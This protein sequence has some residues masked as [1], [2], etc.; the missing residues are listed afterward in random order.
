MSSTSGDDDP[1]SH[2]MVNAMSM[3]GAV[4]DDVSRHSQQ[5]SSSSPRVVHHDGNEKS[6]DLNDERL[7]NTNAQLSSTS[8]GQNITS[9]DDDTLNAS[10]TIS[11]NEQQ[12]EQQQLQ[13]NRTPL[14]NTHSIMNDLQ[15]T[16]QSTTATTATTTETTT[17]TPQQQQRNGIIIL[18]PFHLVHDV[19]EFPINNRYHK[20][21]RPFLERYEEQPHRVRSIDHENVNMILGDWTVLTMDD[22][23]QS[24]YHQVAPPHLYF[25]HHV[26][27]ESSVMQSPKS[28]SNSHVS[29]TTN[30][31]NLPVTFSPQ[32]QQQQQ[33]H[34]QHLM[35]IGN[36]HLRPKQLEEPLPLSTHT[37]M[38]GGAL[39]ITSSLNDHNDSSLH[40]TQQERTTNQWSTPLPAHTGGSNTTTT[41]TTTTTIRTIDNFNTSSIP[42]SSSHYNGTS[43]EIAQRH[44]DRSTHGTTS[45][46]NVLSSNELTYSEEDLDE[47]EEESDLSSINE[48]THTDSLAS[49]TTAA[50]T[51]STGA[52]TTTTSTTTTT[53]TKKHQPGGNLLMNAVINN[54]KQQTKKNTIASLSSSNGSLNGNSSAG[55]IGG[56]NIGNIGTTTTTTDSHYLHQ[57]PA[58]NLSGIAT[59]ATTTTTDHFNTSIQRMPSSSSSTSGTSNTSHLVTTPKRSSP[60]NNQTS[61]TPLNNFIPSTSV[62]N[63][64]NK[65]S[66]GHEMISQNGEYNSSIGIPRVSGVHINSNIMMTSGGIIGSNIHGMTST[67]ATI[68]ATN[69]Y[70]YNDSGGHDAL[71]NDPNASESDGGSSSSIMMVNE[72]VTDIENDALSPQTRNIFEQMGKSTVI[73]LSGSYRHQT[74]SLSDSKRG[75][76]KRLS[77]DHATHLIH[78]SS[79]GGGGMSGTASSQLSFSVVNHPHPERSTIASFEETRRQSVFGRIDSDDEEGDDYDHPTTTV[80]SMTLDGTMSTTATT[81]HKEDYHTNTQM[82]HL[83]DHGALD[84]NNNNGTVS[85]SNSEKKSPNHQM[86]TNSGSSSSRVRSIGQ[87]SDIQNKAKQG[88]RSSFFDFIRKKPKKSNE[89]DSTGEVVAVVEEKKEKMDMIAG[90]SVSQLHEQLYGK[91]KTKKVSIF[92]K[93]KAKGIRPKDLKRIEGFRSTETSMTH[94]ELEDVNRV[95]SYYHNTYFWNGGAEIERCNRMRK[96]PPLYN[97]IS[98]LM[99]LI[100][101]FEEF[102]LSKF[103]LLEPFFCK[104]ALYDVRNDTKL[105]ED[106]CFFI[107]PSNHGASSSSSGSGSS[108]G[109]GSS[110]SNIASNTSTRSQHNNNNTTIGYSFTKLGKSTQRH[111]KAVNKKQNFDKPSALF[112]FEKP[113]HT[114]VYIAFTIEKIYCGSYIEDAW[115]AYKSGNEKATKKYISLMEEYWKASMLRQPFMVFGQKLFYEGKNE[116][117]SHSSVVEVVEGQVKINKAYRIPT[118]SNHPFDTLTFL[119]WLSNTSSNLPIQGSSSSSGYDFHTAFNMDDDKNNMPIKFLFQTNTAT[120]DKLASYLHAFSTRKSKTSSQ[121]HHA[122]LRLTTTDLSMFMND[123]DESSKAVM[124]RLDKSKGSFSVLDT[125]YKLFPVVEPLERIVDQQTSPNG[126][127]YQIDFNLRNTLYIY[128]DTCDLSSLSKTG[129]V[130][131]K[132]SYRK[133]DSAT[134][135]KESRIADNFNPDNSFSF[136]YTCLTHKKVTPQ[137]YDEIRLEI[138]SSA[139]IVDKSHVLFEFYDIDPVRG[140]DSRSPQNSDIDLSSDGITNTQ[141]IGFAFLRDVTN[142]CVVKDGFHTLSIFKSQKLVDNYLSVYTELPISHSSFFTIKTKA[143]TSFYTQDPYTASFL[144]LCDRFYKIFDTLQHQKDHPS[145]MMTRTNEFFSRAEELLH[146]AMTQLDNIREANF[147]ELLNHAPKVMNGLLTLICKLFLLKLQSPM[148]G[149]TTTST[150]TASTTTTSGMTTTWTSSSGHVTL[151][152]EFYDNDQQL[153]FIT[154]A[155]VIV[156]EL[157][158]KAVMCLLFFLNGVETVTNLVGRCNYYISIFISY[159][160]RQHPDIEKPIFKII[161]DEMIT[162]IQ[163]W[164]DMRINEQSKKNPKP[165]DVNVFSPKISDLN[166]RPLSSSTNFPNTTF[167]FSSL[168]ERPNSKQA[169]SL[170]RD[171]KDFI[172]RERKK[173][174]NLKPFKSSMS[175]SSLSMSGSGGSGGATSLGGGGFG[176]FGG[177]TGST[178]TTFEEFNL[179]QTIMNHSESNPIRKISALGF[180]AVDILKFGWFFFDLMVKNVMVL[181]EDEPFRNASSQKFEPESL[182]KRLK[183]L[184]RLVAPLQFECFEK[185]LKDANVYTAAT[186]FNVDLA[187]FLKDMTHMIDFKHV[188]EILM[189]YFTVFEERL[190][191]ERTKDT[192]IFYMLQFLEIFVEHDD[193]YFIIQQSENQFLVQKLIDCVIGGLAQKTDELKTL[194]LKV[195]KNNLTKLDFDERLQ[196]KQDR[197]FIGNLYFDFVKQL[198]EKKEDISECMTFTDELG[199]LFACFYHIIKN[200]ESSRLNEYFSSLGSTQILSLVDILQVTVMLMSIHNQPEVQLCFHE[201][202]LELFDKTIV[203]L[204]L[205]PKSQLYMERA[206][207]I[208]NH[209][210]EN[211]LSLYLSG[212]EDH[213]EAKELIEKL[214]RETLVSEQ[215]PFIGAAAAAAENETYLFYEIFDKSLHFLLSVL[216]LS[217]YLDSEHKRLLFENYLHPFIREFKPFFFINEFMKT[218]GAG[219]ASDEYL[220]TLD[221]QHHRWV[222]PSRLSSKLG[223]LLK[224]T[225]ATATTSHS[226]ALLL[227]PSGERNPKWKPL[228]ASILS[229]CFFPTVSE[230]HHNV[231]EVLYHLLEVY[232]ME[233]IESI[234]RLLVRQE[235]H[236]QKLLSYGGTLHAG[237]KDTPHMTLEELEQLNYLKLEK[238]VE[239]LFENGADY[240]PLPYPEVFFYSYLFFTTP[241]Q[242]LMLIRQCLFKFAQDPHN[243][244]KNVQILNIT[245]SIKLW[246]EKHFSDMNPPFICNLIEFLDNDLTLVIKQVAFECYYLLEQVKLTLINCLLGVDKQLK[247][248]SEESKKKPTPIIPSGFS[249]MKL[250][251][252]TSMTS[253]FEFAQ[254][255]PTEIARQLS[256]IDFEFFKQVDNKELCAPSTPPSK[257]AAFDLTS[258]TLTNQRPHLTQLVQR[259]KDCETWV[260]STI[261]RE[262]DVNKRTEIIFK[263]CQL[264]EELLQLNNI[265]GLF[266]IYRGLS[267]HSILRLV[268]SWSKEAKKIY[269]HIHDTYFARNAIAKENLSQRIN[270]SKHPVIPPIN[271]YLK[272]IRD[273]NLEPTF[274]ISNGSTLINFSK[275]CKLV[276][277]L[278]SLRNFQEVGYNFEPIPYLIKALCV[279]IF[280]EEFLIADDAEALEFSNN[281]ESD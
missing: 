162:F 221:R 200:V 52:N 213:S 89:E 272:S 167:Q 177:G 207:N 139:N 108:S 104:V 64:Y 74:L 233:N 155:R 253:N 126:Y 215:V 236:M 277:V 168:S 175:G 19:N 114:D 12:V 20:D 77:G 75:F 240:K 29:E 65:F 227:N 265:Y 116:N 133:N 111:I 203:Q 173:S 223:G 81:P 9:V 241:N 31:K 44:H 60:R 69:D 70:L 278:Q 258:A 56:G 15:P 149:S 5:V 185:R 254:W 235:S 18:N 142:H 280:D 76:K 276:E 17:T 232:Q 256:L 109:I 252:R 267:H 165:M 263:F 147:A 47:F 40:S 79:H 268:K 82:S 4:L 260:I 112:V 158:S 121:S 255:S 26:A 117:H 100:F 103:G 130:Y 170:I 120:R 107:E 86:S 27:H 199:D 137:F 110:S 249:K 92:T 148:K 91:K 88:N 144:D 163:N 25:N 101:E 10:T 190:N 189:E 166:F 206:C 183:T 154:Q 50:A 150:T 245:L 1:S 243:D 37:T 151:Q 28:S 96:V 210:K 24:N 281:L 36:P 73:Q 156:P 2:Q 13:Q 248:K 80:N 239:K 71:I 172:T 251:L 186:N 3:G 84:H 146:Q 38:N 180:T 257:S 208:L 106:F 14:S 55:H 54:Q 224:P 219:G 41:T 98:K 115:K 6:L 259:N 194:S 226:H 244:Q 238:L 30:S 216:L 237:G 196:S 228:L 45:P 99:Y 63:N 143:A 62:H 246:I 66:F 161:L 67:R 113:N 22:F 123:D 182:V 187:L 72:H 46:T 269:R 273:C 275:C 131:V 271:N 211:L 262:K 95:I 192:A 93:L 129:T 35:M 171:Y 176:G 181:N 102:T 124:A 218:G 122:S 193:L 78:S 85:S 205:L 197:Q 225:T 33:Q 87:L 51:T 39:N 279:D 7:L 136:Y 42:P 209:C 164:Q 179:T 132:V 159:F 184:I 48:M 247:E 217:P 152:N 140:L 178:S 202:Y 250:N 135:T 274:R 201:V 242:L 231:R 157:I 68:D 90:E 229:Y 264:C 23:S 16:L 32:Q 125:F 57:I 214:T 43:T 61:N 191:H 128:P 261:L 141:L 198:I 220:T 127:H 234:D 119:K 97:N 138:P 266:A 230:T 160:A 145:I 195:L 8:Q 153:L 174:S 212:E 169:E 188:R 59:A 94:Y 270:T 134:A 118:H 34:E 21:L 105:T 53:N 58:M 11:N 204:Y 83:L 49:P 222:V